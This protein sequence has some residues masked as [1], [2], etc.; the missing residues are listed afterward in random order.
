MATDVREMT[1]AQAARQ[2][3]LSADWVRK[4]CDRGDLPHR[5]IGPGWRLISRE[6]VEEYARHREEVSA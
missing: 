3:G 6:A 2:L 4:L 5:R 1:V